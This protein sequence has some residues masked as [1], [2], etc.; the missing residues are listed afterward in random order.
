MNMDDICIDIP[1]AKQYFSTMLTK[2]DSF[3]SYDVCR[4][5]ENNDI[6]AGIF[7]QNELKNYL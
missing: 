1:K 4:L 5:I 6:K 2:Y 3:Y 7:S